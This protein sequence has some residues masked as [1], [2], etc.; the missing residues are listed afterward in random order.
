[1]TN[2]KLTPKTEVLPVS[3]RHP[4]TVA[5]PVVDE[6]FYSR[7]VTGGDF[8]AGAITDSYL[9]STTTDTFAL[10]TTAREQAQAIH[11]G[12]MTQVESMLIGQAV[13][14]QSM[15]VDFALR[16]KKASSLQAVQSLAQLALRSQAGSRSTLQVLAEVKN[17]RQV[18]FVK[19][20]NVAHM[21]QVNNGVLP[22]SSSHTEKIAGETNEVL[23]E[24][25]HGCTTLD[26]RAK[27]EAGRAD[28]AVVTLD[29]V[30]RPA[31]R[32]RQTKVIT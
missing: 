18:A 30:D 9:A 4:I 11:Q 31:K 7:L 12:D 13:A 15:F 32:R 25:S 17:P 14:L 1:M 2:K 16:A 23:V 21:Q 20:T 8:A 3:A 26:T 10:M 28:P 29:R 19:Q 27:T 22:P 24:E 5:T 6:T